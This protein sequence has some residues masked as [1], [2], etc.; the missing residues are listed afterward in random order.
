[1]TNEVFEVFKI[2]FSKMSVEPGS[3]AKTLS[4]FKTSCK[5]MSNCLRLSGILVRLIL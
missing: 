2:E 4:N 3:S 5:K 1:M